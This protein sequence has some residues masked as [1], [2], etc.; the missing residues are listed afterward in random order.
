M[1]L[2]PLLVLVLALGCLSATKRSVGDAGATDEA[3]ATDSAV[4]PDEGGTP[5]PGAPADPGTTAGDA[6][7]S[8][9][10]S[11]V[12]ASA[13]TAFCDKCAACKG[14]S[15]FKGKYCVAD[16]FCLTGCKTMIANMLTPETAALFVAGAPSMSCDEFD[17]LFP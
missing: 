3:A 7:V 14:T 9:D 8:A 13:C 16:A 12:F 6:T 5:D 17:G 15:G 4:V 1:K 10:A 2:A 11:A